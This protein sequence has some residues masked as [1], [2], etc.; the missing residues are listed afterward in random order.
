MSDLL[1]EID[2]LAER[3]QGRFTLL[4]AVFGNAGTYRGVLD[5]AGEERRYLNPP[6]SPEDR[7]LECSYAELQRLYSAKLQAFLE[8]TTGLRFSCFKRVDAQDPRYVLINSVNQAYGLSRT[9][10]GAWE[11]AVAACLRDV[12]PGVVQD[13]HKK[14]RALVGPDG[15]YT[16]DETFD[17]R[18]T[19]GAFEPLTW[20]VS[21][22]CSFLSFKSGVHPDVLSAYQDVLS[23][24][25]IR[26]KY[27][28]DQIRDA[29][30]DW[31][32]EKP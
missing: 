30:G 24:V 31:G 5:S 13:L 18:G 12:D 7:A 26:L 20:R 10:Y 17:L 4:E 15:D 6:L 22:K 28:I 25:D 29:L 21:A 14:M 23:Q 8:H 9:E 32:L 19:P 3:L 16:V 11:S 2:Y 27:I 1:D